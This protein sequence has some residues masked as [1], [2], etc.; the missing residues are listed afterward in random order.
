MFIDMY[1]PIHTEKTDLIKIYLK[2]PNLY[3]MYTILTFNY[4]HNF[5]I[6]S[7][8]IYNLLSNKTKLTYYFLF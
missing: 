6:V 3:N 5:S 4:D 2:R 8:Q 7:F 1:K